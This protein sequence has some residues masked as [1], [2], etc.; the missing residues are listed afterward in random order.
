[1]NL[2]CFLSLFLF[3]TSSASIKDKNFPF[4]LFIPRFLEIPTPKF[5]LLTIIFLF[6][7]FLRIF[8]TN[9]KSDLLL[10]S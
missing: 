5:F 7:I 2:I 6:L 3:Q 9:N 4:D 8:S 1:M 10:S